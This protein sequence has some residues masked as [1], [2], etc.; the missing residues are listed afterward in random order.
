MLED[1]KKKGEKA[2]ET[3]MTKAPVKQIPKID[4]HSPSSSIIDLQIKLD[5][6]PSP[7]SIAS[8]SLSSVSSVSSIP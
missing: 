4:D 5:Q 3:G 7:N 6:I 1:G 8:S 2:P